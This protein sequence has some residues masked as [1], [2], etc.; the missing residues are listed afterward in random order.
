MPKLTMNFIETKIERPAQ[1]QVIIRDDE[2]KGFG[3]RVTP[4]LIS[5]ICECRVAGKVRRVTIGK[6]GLPWTPES[7][8]KQ[9]LVIL[10]SM[11][12]G[13]D[14]VAQKAKQKTV[15]LTLAEAFEEFMQS[16][17]FRPL[18]RYNYPRIMH[19]KLGDWLDKPVTAITRDM[20]EQRFRKLSS[21]TEIGTPGKADANLTMTILR[22][23]LNY[24]SL[25]HEVDGVPLIPSNP[26][27][28][29]TPTKAWH[30]IPQRQGVIP[31][32]KLASFAKAV[33]S[34]G[35]PTARDYY[36]VLLLTGLRRNEAPRLLWS[37]IDLEGKVLSVRGDIAKNGI[38]HRLPLSDFL[39]ALFSRRYNERGDS[40]YV[41]PGYRGQGRYYGCYETLKNLR[42]QSECE[43][44]IHDLRRTFLT[45]AERLDTPHFALKKLAGH[46]MR[47][48]I[49]AGYLVIDVERLREPMQRI[50]DKLV[51][52][53]EL[54]I[55]Q[56][57]PEL[58][59][60][61]PNY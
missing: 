51:E 61:T 54:E 4:G 29:L 37:D 56:G 23:T 32:H 40:E 60:R 36:L 44:A 3:L 28:R 55:G 2:L 16:K 24:A 38:E 43:F 21:G 48:D 20:V 26:V 53:M 41:F 35:N 8:R 14:P 17:E 11:A 50:T 31:D 9:A 49:T 33:M 10:G 57:S 34:L 6:H 59:R 25:K 19:K 12:S 58:A 47:G 46:S 42:E 27:S 1:G 18:T 45:M 30:K 5:Y 39:H 13:V 7:A 22:A 15:S 52:L